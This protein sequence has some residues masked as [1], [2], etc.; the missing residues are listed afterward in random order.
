MTRSPSR[1]A[2]SAVCA[3]PTAG[4]DVKGSFDIATVDFEVGGNAVKRL[5]NFA[6]L[7]GAVKDQQAGASPTPG[8]SIPFLA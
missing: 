8:Q 5:G 4:V 3:Q 2:M 1:P 6:G 7:H